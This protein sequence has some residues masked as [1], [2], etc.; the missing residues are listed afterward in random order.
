MIIILIYIHVRGITRKAAALELQVPYSTLCC[1]LQGKT[2]IPTSELERIT[3]YV[4]KRIPAIDVFRMPGWV[5]KET[6]EAIAT[7]LAIEFRNFSF[8]EI[9]YYFPEHT[10]RMGYDEFLRML[11]S[12][13]PD[14]DGN[15]RK[16]VISAKAKGK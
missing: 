8:E 4:R 12:F 3:A 11:S 1:W 9:R 13:L 6:V 7:I 10:K 14:G 2:E 16:E 15:K 5:S